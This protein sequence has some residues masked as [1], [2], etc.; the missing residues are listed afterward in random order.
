MVDWRGGI[1]AETGGCTGIVARW[2]TPPECG[3]LTSS[4]TVMVA[5]WWPSVVYGVTVPVVS[6]GPPHPC[7]VRY[8]VPRSPVPVVSSGPPHSCGVPCLRA[9]PH[10]IR[11]RFPGPPHPIRSWCPAPPH[12][13]LTPLRILSAFSL[14][15]SN[16]GA[17]ARAAGYSRHYSVTGPTWRRHRP[18]TGWPPL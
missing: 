8:P 3:R 1:A 15:A 4:C 9:P 17:L 7:L 10:P 6:H 14:S 18:R 13:C 16:S 11:S 12:T 2:W 5:L